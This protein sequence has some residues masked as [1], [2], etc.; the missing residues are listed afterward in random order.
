MRGYAQLNSFH[1]TDETGVSSTVV[2]HAT[3]TQTATG[4]EAPP[5]GPPHAARKR[6]SAHAAVE[7]TFWQYVGVFLLAAGTF[8]SRGPRVMVIRGLAGASTC[9]SA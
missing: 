9:S 2:H 7:V 1:F 3:A 4:T 5:P 6:G 8:A